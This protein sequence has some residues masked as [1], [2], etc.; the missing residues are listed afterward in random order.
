[1]MKRTRRKHSPTFKAKV[2][3]AAIKNELTLPELAKRFDVHPNQ[4]TQWKTQLLERAADAFGA[5]A[6]RAVAPTVD[7]KSLQAK[8][9]QLAMEN[10]FLGRRARSAGRCE[11]QAMIDK[12]DE[13]PVTRQVQLLEL[14]RSSAYYTPRPVSQHD[15]MLMRRIDALHMAYP[16][17]G[18]RMLRGL[19]G[20]EGFKVGRRH[21]ARLMRRMG[22]EALFRGPRTSTPH[23]AHKIYPYLLRGLTIDRPNQVWA[24]DITYLPMA[25]GFVYLCAVLDWHTRRVLSWRLSN[26]L[27]TDFCI[28]AVE[29]AIARHGRPEIFNTDQGCQFT[30]DA[31]VGLLQRHEIQISMDG[32]GAWR[33]NVFVERLW[34]TVKYEEVYLH[35]YESVAQAKQRLARYFQ[36]YNEKRPHTGLDGRTP[37]QAYFAEPTRLAA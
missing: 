36:F 3:L 20:D 35:A 12:G 7:V 8:I 28:E 22:I 29:E 25:H 23:P 11:R 9:G 10:D 33:D 6:D 27:T 1:M 31:F 5:G 15:L 19:L 16:F 17:A 18:S 24:T 21:I 2:A 30:S 37:D 32:K 13:L 34:R 26:T 14:S 4:I